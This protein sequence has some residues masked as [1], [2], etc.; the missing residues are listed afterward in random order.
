MRRSLI[1]VSSAVA[2][3]GALALAGAPAASAASLE[4][5]VASSYASAQGLL[6]ITYDTVL[7]YDNA[8]QHGS[9]DTPITP[10]AALQTLITQD[11]TIST[12]AQISADVTPAFASALWATL[13]GANLTAGHSNIDAGDDFGATAASFYGSA[14]AEPSSLQQLSSL[15][16]SAGLSALLAT[17]SNVT[18]TTSD[19][20]NLAATN[21]ANL[22]ALA[23]FATDDP[24]DFPGGL[25]SVDGDVSLSTSAT[26]TGLG[27]PTLYTTKMS[28]SGSA[29]T[30]YVLPSQFTL[31]FP[32]VFGINAGLVSKE[33]QPSQASNPPTSDAIGTATVVSPAIAA[34]VPGSKGVDNTATVYAVANPN[35]SDITHPSFE[36]Y[37]GQG[38]YISGTLSGVSFP[39]TVTFGEPQVGGQSVPLPF[40]S[41]SMTFPVATSPLEAESCTDLS[42]LT[43]T[44]TDGAAAIAAAAGD[45]ADSGA[46]PLAASPTVVT[47]ECPAIAAAR[48]RG[49]KHGKPSLRITL[50]GNGGTPFTSEMLTLPSGLSAKGLKAKDLKVIGA[51]VKSVSG[52]G[53]KVTITFRSKTA[54]ANVLFKAGLVASSK[55]VRS[56]SKHKTK[57]LKLTYS[58][59]YAPTGAAAA[60]STATTLTVK[61]LS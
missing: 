48:I 45:T 17:P 3:G 29:S 7:A 25:F 35:A 46:V 38:D 54:S 18:S 36:V 31:T 58:V 8:V 61:G 30:G 9:G 28:V 60:A 16:G 57:S 40:S 41:F 44:M 33:I 49:I 6:A 12:Q 21:L 13:A 5:T 26:V 14:S 24:T 11:G 39:L 23:S 55:L 4:P 56:V 10:T 2:A 37:L 51:K 42:E 20:I 53:A 15:A 52:K 19:A 22:Q 34:L 43:G 32:A 50:K 59:E 1:A 47:D 27:Q